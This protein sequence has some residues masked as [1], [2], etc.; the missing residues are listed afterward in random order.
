MLG[1]ISHTHAS[2]L[3]DGNALW[4]H[5]QQLPKVEL[6]AHLG[7]S[8]RL[9]TLRDLALALPD[10]ADLLDKIDGCQVYLSAPH[11]HGDQDTWDIGRS[12][13]CS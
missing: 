6:H 8:V 1:F 3:M 7:G 13:L 11:V 4:A 10:S 12:T 2:D 9:S 5:C